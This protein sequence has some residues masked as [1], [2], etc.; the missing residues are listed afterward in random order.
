MSRLDE[1]IAELCPD[2][3]EYKTLGKVALIELGKRVTKAE[4]ER[5]PGKYPVWHGGETPMGYI[6]KT[7]CPPNTVL[8]A[9]TGS[10][11]YVN[12]INI[13]SWCSDAASMVIAK[14]DILCSRF[15]YHFLKSKEFKIK[16]FRRV[17]GVPT[18]ELRKLRSF[19]IPVPPLPVQREIVRILDNF[20]EL[21]AEL[22]AELNA[23]LTARKKQYEYY[24][25]LLLMFGND[26][27]RVALGDV[28]RY[29][30]ERISATELNA[31]TY[32][33]VDNL[34]SDKRGKTESN[35]VPENGMCTKY[36]KGNVLIGNIRPYLKKIWRATNTGGT[37]GDVLVIQLTDNRIISE[38]LYYLLSSDKFFA[39]DMQN[40]KGAKMPRGDKAAIMKYSVPVPPL[41][42]Q[43]RIVAILDRFDALCNDLT[44]GIPAEIEARQKQY[45]YYRDKLLSF[46]EVT[47]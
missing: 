18:L 36:Q 5:N 16:K 33:G 10:I 2:G 44:S 34:L 40:S 11:G 29:S 4:I 35:Y 24:R 3:V 9:N 6:N 21:T 45:E 38:Y 13:D 30:K 32:V 43:E 15:L 27:P 1:L 39:Y 28:S 41:E 22:T 37:N 42:E 26:V 23:E 7:N 19:P 12:W 8:V 46:K 17:G 47:A 20:T 31:D 25:D 14:K